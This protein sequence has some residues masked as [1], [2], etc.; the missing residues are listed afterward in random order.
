[1]TRKATKASP[2]FGFHPASLEWLFPVCSTG[3]MGILRTPAGSEASGRSRQRNE[4]PHRGKAQRLGAGDIVRTAKRICQHSGRSLGGVLAGNE[5]A[6]RFVRQTAHHPMGIEPFQKHVQIE[7][8][9]KH[10]IRGTCRCKVGETKLRRDMA[11]PAAIR[12]TYVFRERAT[13]RQGCD[14]RLVPERLQVCPPPQIGG[15]PANKLFS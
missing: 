3:L 4:G 9:S 14:C 10:G 13:M 8:V 11:R 12:S 7:C 2:S 6:S 15:R 5:G 1:M